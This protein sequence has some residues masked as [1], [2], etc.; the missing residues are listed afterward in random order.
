MTNWKISMFNR[1]YIDSFMVAFPASHVTFQGGVYH[2][3]PTVHVNKYLVGG[4]NPYEK[5]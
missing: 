5:Y 4:F 3:K 1:K 2:K